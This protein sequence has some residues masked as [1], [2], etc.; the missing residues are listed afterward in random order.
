M[1]V[2]VDANV[3]LEIFVN[4]N[5][6]G[7]E[8]EEF[9]TEMA[10]SQQTEVY[11][12]EQCLD[13]V[14]F[15]LSRLDSQ[16]ASKADFMV[17]ELLHERIIPVD[18]SMLDRARSFEITNFESAVEVACAIDRNLDLVVTQNPQSFVGAT[19]PIFSVGELGQLL[20]CCSR[21]RTLLAAGW[22]QAADDETG[23]I[24]L[25]IGDGNKRGWL[26]SE[27]IMRLPCGLLHIL[28]RFWVDSS[29][30]RYG[31][32]VQRMLWMEVR[33][34]P[35]V[36]VRDAW[37]NFVGCVGWCANNSQEPPGY[38]PVAGEAFRERIGLIWGEEGPTLLSRL[39]ACSL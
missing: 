1:R 38:Y 30:G 15:C 23:Q 20:H 35:G 5:G 36:S 39:S 24:L 34:Q 14:R 21:L 33:N 25:R 32:S 9:L 10:Q 17:R 29:N 26:D 18:L 7:E 31:F 22:W 3:I 28:D 16:S 19:L 27:D 13:K 6:F 12:T 11:A 8:A 4:R 2:L 37:D